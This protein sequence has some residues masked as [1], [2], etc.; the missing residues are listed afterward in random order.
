[1]LEGIGA[2]E[3]G[4]TMGDKLLVG[5]EGST[6]SR[7]ALEWAAAEAARRRGRLIVVVVVDHASLTDCPPS[8]L[9]RRWQALH[10]RAAGLA[11]SAARLVHDV[12]PA[13]DFEVT[14]EVGAPA[15]VLVAASHRGD[16]M[17]LGGSRY[18]GRRTR[19]Q[20]ILVEAVAAHARCPVLVVGSAYAKHA[21]AARPVVVGVDGSSRADHA[22]VVAA[23]TAKATGS[24]LH[25]VCVWSRAAPTSPG[26]RPPGAALDERTARR[27]AESAV[28]WARSAYPGVRANAV[29]TA[30]YPPTV[31]L[32]LAR[33]SGLLV[34]G[35][36]SVGGRST[37]V[38]GSVARTALRALPCPVALVGLTS[39]P[40]DRAPATA[41]VLSGVPVG[42]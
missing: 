38:F 32:R 26:P 27:M 19:H 37:L 11:A 20:V 15:A 17:V 23:A 41:P 16:V 36:R 2:R 7:W 29:V 8:Q 9:V 39:R 13:L 5:Y 35:R 40:L 24:P 10:A 33:T 1:M 4:R 18:P 25:V 31:L 28:A 22:L 3:R 21:G 30:G 42:Q 12:A 14:S 34:L 6:C